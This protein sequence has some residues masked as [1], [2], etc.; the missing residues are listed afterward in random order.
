MSYS[1]EYNAGA[2]LAAPSLEADWNMLNVSNFNRE[3]TVRML[4][5]VAGIA[6]GGNGLGFVDDTDAMARLIGLPLV[7]GTAL[8][9]QIGNLGFFVLVAGGMAICGAITRSP[10]FFY[11]AAALIGCVAVFRIFATVA[12]GAPLSI[13][14]VAVELMVLVL[15]LAAGSFLQRRGGFILPA[16]GAD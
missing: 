12:Y 13:V 7:E 9:S 11:C 14:F 16:S 8:A 10:I 4:A 6:I 5:A 15:W 1:A 2:F 3:Q